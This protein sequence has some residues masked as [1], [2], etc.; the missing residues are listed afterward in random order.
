[1]KHLLIALLLSF[2]LSANAETFF[3][4]E[5]KQKH[6]L[7]SAA[8]AAVWM[9]MTESKKEAFWTLIA[10]GVLKEISDGDRNSTE[11]HLGDFAAGALGASTVF[12]WKYEF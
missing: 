5:D 6:M 7:Y 9:V 2:S 10:L 4:Q 11:E 1:M 3:E 8:G 12:L